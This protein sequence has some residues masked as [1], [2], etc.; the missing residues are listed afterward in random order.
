MNKHSQETGEP[1]LNFNM[2]SAEDIQR[3]Y[4]DEMYKFNYKIFK[5]GKKWKMMIKREKVERE[6]E[7]KIMNKFV[8][9][10]TL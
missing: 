10:F 7:V 9:F 5:I 2:Y 1:P 8:L 4:G 6:R 3:Q